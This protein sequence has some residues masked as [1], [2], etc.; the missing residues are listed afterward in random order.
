VVG[1][2]RVRE[3]V[4]GG[5]RGRRRGGRQAPQRA[6]VP[7]QRTANVKPSN[8]LL[9]ERGGAYVSECELMRYATNIQQSIAPQATRTRHPDAVPARAVPG[10]G[11][12]HDVGARVERRERVA[13]VR[14]PGAGFRRGRAGDAG[15]GR[16][17]L[18]NGALEVMAGECSDETM[19][20]V[21]IGMLCTTRGAAH[22][23][24][25]ARHD[26][27]VRVKLV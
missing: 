1:Q 7:R 20:M 19:G 18:R 17:Q 23:G 11:R 6:A 4:Q 12:G 5:A 10:V 8:I 15:I 27:R 13:R 24:A 25:G 26:E 14:D 22:D 16:V 9:G 3:H 21:K 2:G